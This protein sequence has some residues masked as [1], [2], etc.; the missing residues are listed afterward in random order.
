V[1]CFAHTSFNISV[2]ISLSDRH[3]SLASNP[4]FNPTVF[5]PVMT[6]PAVN[7]IITIDAEEDNWGHAVGASPVENIRMV[8]RLQALFDRYKI[9]PTYLVSYEVASCDWAARIFSDIASRSGCEIGTHLHPWNTPPVRE[10]INET[11]SMMKNLPYELQLEKLDVLTEKIE[12]VFGTRPR[13]FRAGRWGLGENTIKALI[14]CGYLVDS[15]VTPTIS[16]K[17]SGDGP[18]YRDMHIEPYWL[19][20]G[21]GEAEANIKKAILEVPVTIGF[22]KWPFEFWQKIYHQLQQDW[23]RTLHPIGIL[24]RTGL[25][26]KIWLTPEGQ[27]A[28]DMLALVKI[29]VSNGMKT[30]NMSFH[31]TS[32]LPGKSPFVRDEK[33][34]ELF[35]A[36]IER[37][38]EF[39]TSNTNVSSLTLSEVVHRNKLL[40][41]EQ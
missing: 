36:K 25:L 16:W 38:L 35:Y 2:F 23:L 15:S 20:D 22:N 21:T 39:V 18:E 32:L 13:S 37:V 4:D 40:E 6:L 33:D 30:M 3:F 8:P 26:K 10:T 1:R 28:D 24:S 7:F 27:S 19:S 41:V 31:T 11:N 14:A 9:R 12:K 5:Q 34:L 29:M 17:S